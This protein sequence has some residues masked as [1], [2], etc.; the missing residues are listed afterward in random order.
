MANLRITNVFAPVIHLRR[1]DLFYPQLSY[2]IVGILF[3]VYN[4]I[5]PGHHEKYYQR[6]IAQALR[7]EGLKFQEQ[8]SLPVS[9]R[10]K[11]VGRYQLDFLVEGKVILEIKKDNRF[12]KRHIDQVLAY[13]Q[14]FSLRLAILSNFT[15]DG[16]IFKRVVNFME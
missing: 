2:K 9:Y 7:A 15:R 12:S 8:V 5:G 11:S 4:D 10:G 13:L 16:V 6:C 1:E 14:S 3:S